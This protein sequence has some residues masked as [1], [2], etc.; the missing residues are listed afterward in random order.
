MEEQNKMMYR[1]KKTGDLYR[2][3]DWGVIDATNGQEHRAEMIL[4]ENQE[5][6]PF[7]RD[8]VEFLN[9]FEEVELKDF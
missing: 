8:E 9:K 7:V 6:Q 3:I 5:G 4:Y 2:V 1:N